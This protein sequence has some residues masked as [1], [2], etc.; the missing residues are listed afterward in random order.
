MEKNRTIIKRTA[1]F[2]TLIVILVLF[3]GALTA[4]SEGLSGSYTRTNDN[5]DV[6]TFTFSGSNKVKNEIVSPDGV[7]EYSRTT[8]YK[9]SNGKIIFS[10]W[11]DGLEGR[12][13]NLIIGEKS[14]FLDEYE[15]IK[16]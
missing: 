12:E 13:R 9:I 14:I 15:Y 8:T 6:V 3:L 2:A 16:K 4:C 7:V 1:T 10:K 5:G 11:S